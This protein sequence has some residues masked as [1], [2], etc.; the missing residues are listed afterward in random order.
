[1][2]KK[3]KRYGTDKVF[4]NVLRNVGDSTVNKE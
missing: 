2:K 4:L 1:M 3:K